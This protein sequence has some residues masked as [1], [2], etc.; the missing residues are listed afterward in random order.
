MLVGLVIPEVG[1]ALQREARQ[2]KQFCSVNN[3]C[4][5]QT[6]S[7]DKTL[8]WLSATHVSLIREATCQVHD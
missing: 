2:V 5:Y 8:R 1:M 7:R 4:N 6:T 3:T